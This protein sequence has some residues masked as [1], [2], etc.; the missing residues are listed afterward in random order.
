MATSVDRMQ[1]I[2]LAIHNSGTEK[3]H[4]KKNT[5]IQLKNFKKRTCFRC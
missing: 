4:N 2:F 5:E 1:F 3:K